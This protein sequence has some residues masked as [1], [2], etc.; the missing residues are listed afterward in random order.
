MNNRTIILVVVALMCGAGA[1]YLV[2]RYVNDEITEYRQ[3]VDARY[4]PVQVVV[5]ANDLSRGE[6]LNSSN[7]Q[8]R[9]V[10][11]S[12]VHRDAV[13]PS[14]VDSVMGANLVYALGSGEPLLATHIQH[15]NVD[16]F[17]NLIEVGKRAMTFPVDTLS[18]ISGMI[19][20]G[21]IIDIFG[22]LK[23]GEV[24]NTVPLLQNI[25]VMA[26]GETVRENEQAVRNSN[27]LRYQ[28]ITLHVEPEIAARIAHARSVGTLSVALRS[29]IDQLP[30]EFEPVTTRTLLGKAAYRQIPIIRG[31]S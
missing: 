12:F 18:S 2:N 1:L 6:T 21:D 14:E 5:A 27:Q 23:N 10:P 15:S 7:L 29:R 11:K 19:S 13:R 26:T 30:M 22:T 3:S 25:R 9:E 24:E 28:T 4:E 8:V 16:S 31:G 20:P 17:S